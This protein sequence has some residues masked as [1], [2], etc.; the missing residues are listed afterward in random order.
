MRAFL[1][2]ISVTTAL[3]ALVVLPGCGSGGRN[4]QGV[5]FTLFG[6]FE[7]GS[8]G[9]CDQG[10]SG[11]V[12]P[13]SAGDSPEALGSI[14]EVEVQLGLQNNLLGQ[15]IRVDRAF[16]DYRIAGASVAVPS[17]SFGVGGVLSPIDGNGS[18]LPESLV[19]STNVPNFICSDV[20]IVPAQVVEFINFNRASLPEPP[21]QMNVRVRVTGETSS[22]SRLE[23]NN[24][25]FTVDVTPD[26]IIAP[27]PGETTTG[28]V[29]EED[30][31]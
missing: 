23:T 14:Q 31:I 1:R 3:I 15:T 8:S 7:A 26:N 10:L 4:D 30:T 2:I 22:G 24:L 25:D 11:A 5:S 17:S 27:T 21:Y 18:T 6:F 16:M 29:V 9:A 19:G 20:P 13:L 12:V 28:A